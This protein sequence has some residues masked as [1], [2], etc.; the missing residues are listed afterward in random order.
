MT[1]LM[2][3]LEFPTSDM[4]Y[5]CIY[6]HMYMH[7]YYNMQTCQ[8]IRLIECV[9]GNLLASQ[10]LTDVGANISTNIRFC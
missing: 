9:S 6:I 2:K 4:T 1:Q 8:V 10:I 3:T 5:T 7:V